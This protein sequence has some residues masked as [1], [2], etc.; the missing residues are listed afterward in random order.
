MNK[1]VIIIFTV[2]IILTIFPII[3]SSFLQNDEDYLNKDFPIDIKVDPTVELF[4][5]IHRLANTDQ[6]TS[7]NFPQYISDVED[8]F[9]RYTSHKAVNLAIQQRNQNGING[10]APM[11]LAV[12]LNSPPSLTS[13]NSFSPYP[14]GLDYRWTETEINEFIDAAKSFS[15]NSDF[16]DFFN[17]KKKCIIRVLIIY[18]TTLRK[19]VFYNGLK[20]TL[21]INPVNI[22]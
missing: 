17:S 21:V 7:D 18:T 9:E 16:M 4:C 5:T 19:I 13:K 8:Y 3:F 20:C 10:S 11:S 2:I 15:T 1:K 22:Q 14:E 12:Y 6:Y